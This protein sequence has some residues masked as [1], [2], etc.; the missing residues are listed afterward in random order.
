MMRSAS[1]VLLEINTGQEA[2]FY[3]NTGIAL[4]LRFI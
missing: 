2:G 4:I 1:I 3:E